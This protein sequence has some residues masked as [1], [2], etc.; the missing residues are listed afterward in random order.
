MSLSV[1]ICIT[2]GTSSL[3]IV[4]IYSNVDSYANPIQ[5]NI[6]IASLI[7]PNCPY[8]LDVPNNTNIIRILDNTTRCLVDLPILTNL[9]TCAVLF[10]DGNSG[11]VFYY[12]VSTNQ[13]T[14]LPI[15]GGVNYSTDIAHTNDKLWLTSGNTGLKEY[16]IVL[17]PFS[18]VFNRVIPYPV[19][20]TASNGLGAIDNTTILAVNA[21]TTPHSVVEIDISNPI[22]VMNTK[23]SLN[24]NR[25]V[26]GDFYK[27]TTDKF[28]VTLTTITAPTNYFI[29]Q[30][31][32]LSETLDVEIPLTITSNLGIFEDNGNIYIGEGNQSGTFGNVYQIDTSSPYNVTLMNNTGLFIAGASQVPNCL[33]VDFNKPPAVTPTSTQT[34]TP[35]NTVTPT[36]TPTITQTPTPTI[37]PTN[38][39]TPTV[40]PTPG[41]SPTTTP[42]ITPT[43]TITTTITPTNTVT[44]TPTNTVTPTKTSTP[45]ITPT[46]TITPTMSN[47][48]TKTPTIT[49]TNTV[50]PTITPTTPILSLKYQTKINMCDTGLLNYRITVLKNNLPFEEYVVNSSNP[51]YCGFDGVLTPV[52]TFDVIEVNGSSDTLPFNFAVY[53]VS[54]GVNA[55]L[56][57]S[58]TYSQNYT[59]TIY[60]QYSTYELL[61]WDNIMPT[62]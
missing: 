48:P 12:N 19:G 37:T 11:L 54:A 42:T 52:S 22:A 28:I 20:Y 9:P 39:V 43:P 56:Y 1:S 23:F 7:A 60:N 14:S 36:V 55:L 10:T 57:S 59:F 26:T 5:Q 2:A 6:P 50:T 44:Q 40:T 16:N 8:V 51:A 41:A 3:N 18:A 21:F 29:A 46:N 17:Q 4:N 49:P 25:K 13:T 32:Y 58:N 24:N 34:P 45:T 27:T 47:T 15:P 31:D 38:T 33:T 53:G 35:T 62:P 61:V 30:Y